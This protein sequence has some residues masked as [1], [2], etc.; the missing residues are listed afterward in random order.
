MP[1]IDTCAICKRPI[2][3]FDRFVT[4]GY[5]LPEPMYTLCP[6]CAA[7]VTRLLDE[8]GLRRFSEL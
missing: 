8:H 3:D 5:G 4:V 2:T 6:G 1:H 7:P